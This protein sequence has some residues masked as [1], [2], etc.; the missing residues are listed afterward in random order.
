MKQPAEASRDANRV[1]AVGPVEAWET[2]PAGDALDAAGER[3]VDSLDDVGVE[4]LPRLPDGD[5][6]VDRE[7]A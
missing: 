6:H 3:V 4:H 1:V 2:R 5:V 7:L